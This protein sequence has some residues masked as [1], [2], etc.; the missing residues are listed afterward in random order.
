MPLVDGGRPAAAPRAGL[1]RLGL[2]LAAGYWVAE[3]LIHTFVFGS[4][5]LAANLLALRDPDELWMRSLIVV[6]LAGFGAIAERSVRAERRL[7]EDARQLDS[8][9]RFVDRVRQASQQ[10]PVDTSAAFPDRRQAGT[11]GPVGRSRRIEDL[12][13]REDELGQLSRMLWELSSLVEARFR[14][15]Y[16]LLQLSHEI[17][18]GLILDEV[19]G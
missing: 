10:G 1:F 18:Q 12:A 13:G 15:L 5:S 8:L 17:S 2:V 11:S 7:K 19:L 3:S 16:A 6:L 4:G 14:E 9:G